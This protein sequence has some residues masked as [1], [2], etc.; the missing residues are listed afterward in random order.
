MITSF[1]RIIKYG[2]QNFTRNGWL[3]IATTAIVTMTLLVLMSLMIFDVISETALR[4]VQEKIDISV[5]F[6]P[7][8][9]EETIRD[10][11]NRL[12]AISEIKSIEYISSDRALEIFRERHVGDAT[13]SQAI[14]E[15]NGNP[16]LA[17]LVIKAHSPDDYAL[18]DKRIRDIDQAFVGNLDV[19][20]ADDSGDSPKDREIELTPVTTIDKVTFTENQL[21]IERLTK[22]IN[23]LQ[24]IGLGVTL[25]LAAIAILITFNTVRLAIYSN[26]EELGVMRLVGAAN[27]FI[28]GPYLITGVLY[29]IVA[30]IVSV[31]VALPFVRLADPQISALI[32][33]LSL[34]SY[35]NQNLIRLL[36]LQI[37]VGALL[38]A[39]SSAIAIR[40]YLKI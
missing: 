8:I 36:G 32:P 25:M 15:L 27:S 16:L 22:I 3:S 18:I 12:G 37:I 23:T 24:T 39:V 19:P 2:F 40:K 9:A 29:G 14:E 31:L 17:S 33:E 1:L 11:E 13:V 10:F 20:V 6:R 7:E 28:N 5:Y 21:V 38:G 34:A 4:S 35:F 30:A 26:R